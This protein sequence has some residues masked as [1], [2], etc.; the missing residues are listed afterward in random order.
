MRFHPIL[1][2]LLSSWGASRGTAA[3][4]D[5]T[6]GGGL[7]G[8]L[9]LAAGRDDDRS[10]MEMDMYGPLHCNTDA[11]PSITS[12]EC[13]TNATPLS[14][15]INDA[16]TSSSN[17]IVPCG[18]CV[19]VDYTDRSTVTLPG[20]GSLHI[21][22][23]LHFPPTSSVA[24]N[25]TAIFIEGLLD[26]PH[27]I[28]DDNE[29]KFSL[30]GKDGWFY[31]PHEKCTHGDLNCMHKKDVGK[32]PVVVAG[33][34]KMIV[35]ILMNVCISLAV[36]HT[37]SVTILLVH[38][39]SKCTLGT[40]DIRNADASCPTWTTLK[41]VTTIG[42]SPKNAK[43]L[44]K[45]FVLD[46]DFVS[47]ARVNDKIVVTSNTYAGW[48]EH[49]ELK[50]ESIDTASNTI[51]MVGSTD[52]SFATQVSSSIDNDD[53]EHIFP[54][55]VAILRRNVIFEG[56]RQ[57]K[58]EYFKIRRESDINDLQWKSDL[59]SS[60]TTDFTTTDISGGFVQ[61]TKSSGMG[62]I[63][64]TYA[65]ATKSTWYIGRVED[66][67]CQVQLKK[68]GVVVNT[69]PPG[70]FMTR[71]FSV[72][73]QAGDVLSLTEDKCM[74]AVISIEHLTRM[75]DVDPTDPED[76]HAAHFMV[77][78]TPNVEQRIEGVQFDNMGQAGK[79]GR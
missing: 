7:R 67:N 32:K 68:N 34:K 40:V 29:V 70:K 11:V 14:S 2:F 48:D 55:E 35:H 77:M 28:H 27:G 3:A 57:F 33:G 17:V 4:E 19:K 69:V 10:L 41:D 64:L 38:I 15:I 36:S 12:D 5:G 1:S 18:S 73:V 43:T 58:K 72:D 79:L 9:A 24:L 45:G 30:Y 8:T 46:Q 76:I 50:V 52:K 78:H 47:C 23:R 37:F 42:T 22:G 66:S 61:F 39:S 74:A 25:S 16:V 6:G 71:T 51:E 75:M 20:D 21:K 59:V 65:Q 49:F 13:L 56:Q 31:Y 63:A 44:T 26:I 60:V 62:S 54:S 53:Q